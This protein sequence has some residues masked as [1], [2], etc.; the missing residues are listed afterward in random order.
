MTKFVALVALLTFYFSHVSTGALAA[1]K[2]VALIVANASYKAGDKLANPLSDSTIVAEALK[3][4]KF[5][6]VELKT[7]VGIAQFRQALRQFRSQ[8]DGA[9]VALAYFAGHGVEVDGT[10]WLIP[11]DAELREVRDLE[12]E[13]VRLDLLLQ[14]LGGA[15]VRIVALDACRNN[16]FSAGWR[17]ASRSLTRGLGRQEADGVLVLFAAAPGQVASDGEGKNSPFAAALAKRLPEEGLAIQLLGGRVRD[18]VLAA[19]GNTQRAFVSA[20]ITGEP[21]YLV[22]ST[23]TKPAAT[24]EIELLFWSSVK[25][26]TSAAVLRTYLDRYPKGEFSTIARA[27]IQH[28]EQ[29]A[30]LSLAAREEESRR[31]DETRKEAELKRLELERRTREAELAQD[32]I[33]AKRAKDELE[34]KRIEERERQ[35]HAARQDELRKAHEQARIAKQAS[36]A[37]EEDRLAAARAADSAAKAAVAEIEAKKKAAK[38]DDTNKIAALSVPAPTPA[39][40][41]GYCNV[42]RFRGATTGGANATMTV[43]HGTNC[44]FR[45]WSSIK[46]NIT[47][48]RLSVSVQPSSGTVKIVGN[49]VTY[50]SRDGFRGTDRFTVSGHGKLSSGEQRNYVVRMTVSVVD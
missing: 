21:F 18:D 22:P 36:K 45:N 38:K 43:S 48:D 40:S 24:Q 25:D 44:S 1:S 13:A 15:R 41:K 26:S 19:T 50:R 16:P 9:E 17:S 8:A 47:P 28:Y 2:R 31:Q 33:R 30:K 29:Q 46:A 42:P 10:N 6:V 35:E 23:K 11:T 4:A 5:N 34:V 37:A 27:L 3:H 12:Y 14:A 7:D 49:R 32:R 20:S 39:P